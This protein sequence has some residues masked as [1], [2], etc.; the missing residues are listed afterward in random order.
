MV[1]RC[2]CDMRFV[3]L[4]VQ[5]YKSF[6]RA[7]V[8]RFGPG[9]NVV[10]G[11]NN[12]GKTALL[13]AASLQFEQRQHRSPTTVPESGPYDQGLSSVSFTFEVSNDE[14]WEVLA[15][16]RRV[17]VPLPQH[18]TPAL[19]TQEAHHLLAL[20]DRVLAQPT[21]DFS[22]VFVPPSN[23]S[24][25]RYPTFGTYEAW[26][27]HGNSQLIFAMCDVDLQ[28]RKVIGA[29]ASADAAVKEFGYDVVEAFRQRV[30]LFRAERRIGRALVEATDVLMP[31][32]SNLAAVL[33]RLQANPMRFSRFSRL[34]TEVFDDIKAVSV[35]PVGSE[36]E[37]LLWFDDPIAE[38]EDLAVPVTEAGTGT[39]QV[40]AMLYVLVTARAGRVLLIDEPQ[41]F[42]HPGAV[43]NL[44]EIARRFPQHQFI[45][46]TH[47]PSVISSAAPSTLHRVQLLER[48]SIVSPVDPQEPTQLREL[49]GDVGATL[50]DVFGADRVLWVE[51]A[52]EE[53]VFPLLLHAFGYS[54]TGT[55]IVGVKAVGDFER[56][57]DLVVDL[58]H[59]VSSFALLPAAVG[60]IFDAEARSADRKR[61][62]ERRSGG[63][64]QFLPRPMF[65]NYLLHPRAIASVLAEAC[66][67]V[68]TDKT[69][70]EWIAANWER[71]RLLPGSVHEECVSG[72]KLLE[73]L[74]AELTQAQ[75]EYRKTV[76]GFEITKSLLVMDPQHLKDLAEFIALSAGAKEA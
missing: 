20:A 5:N 16:A 55:A 56:R 21:L 72:A 58:Y 2:R 14:L 39:G 42:L 53:I 44:I 37:I 30:Y 51:G 75:V 52:T 64:V 12:A 74:F 4:E 33:D 9:F 31:D 24:A 23:M 47:S 66:S 28:N 70:A 15:A 48:E 40:L 62:L 22:F 29:R 46:T 54:V 1:Q 59:R 71:F 34:V 41:S 19:P 49:L 18:G 43:R 61:D 3:S 65:E 32:A 73:R 35:R 76:H 50:A 36:R 17:Q 10:F 8:A 11:R 6:R 69:I 63:R 57:H 27:P 13:E 68:V 26:Q 25:P 67:A 60:F 45:L 7:Q 38:R